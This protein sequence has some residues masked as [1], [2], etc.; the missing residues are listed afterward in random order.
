MD[1]SWHVP[2]G[3]GNLFFLKVVLAGATNGAG[4]II[5]QILEL[6]SRNHAIVRVA[7]GRIINIPTDLTYITVHRI[8]S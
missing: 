1:V 4:P 3:M 7:F 5:S 6:G 2:R 8:P